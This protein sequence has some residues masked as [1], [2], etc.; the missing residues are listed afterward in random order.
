MMEFSDYQCY[1]YIALLL[2]HE[3]LTTEETNPSPFSTI[4]N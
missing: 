3:P 1:V 4:E 2:S